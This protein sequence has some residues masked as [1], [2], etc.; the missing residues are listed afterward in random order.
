[1]RNRDEM[2]GFMMLIRAL[3]G[4]ENVI[5]N[6]EAEGQQEAIRR[7]L[8][9]RRMYPSQADWE[10]LGFTFVDIP[11]DSVMYQAELPEGWSIEA[12]SHSMHSN[13]L[14]AN[15]LKRGSMFYKASFYD[16]NASMSLERRYNINRRYFEEEP[17]TFEVYFGNEQEILFVAGKVVKPTNGTE[18]E[19]DAAYAEAARLEQIALEWANEHYPDWENVHAYWDDTLTKKNQ[20]RTLK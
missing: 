11:D 14:D 6:M 19:I 13:I 17:R 12:T 1:M 5:E 2:D 20:G 16:R 4:E 8:L 15:G 18:E 10:S 9:A 7:T 3:S